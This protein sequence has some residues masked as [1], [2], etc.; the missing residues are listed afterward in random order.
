MEPVSKA[1]WLRWVPSLPGKWIFTMILAG[2]QILAPCRLLH[3]YTVRMKMQDFINRPR[4]E[5]QCR[6]RYIKC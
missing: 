1:T 6:V 4:L 3:V 5:L 2:R